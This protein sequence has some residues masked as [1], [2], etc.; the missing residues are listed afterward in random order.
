M[1][2]YFPEAHVAVEVIPEPEGLPQAQ[3]PPDTVRLYVSEEQVS[4][5]MI[6]EALGDLVHQREKKLNRER[7]AKVCSAP[8]DPAFAGVATPDWRGHKA[9][10]LDG[11]AA[12]ATECDRRGEDRP[13]AEDEARSPEELIEDLL[14][15]QDELAASLAEL[16][17]ELLISPDLDCFEGDDEDEDET[18]TYDDLGAYDSWFQD[19][20]DELCCA[21]TRSMRRPGR[22]IN[23]GG[24]RNLYLSV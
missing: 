23:I 8:L 19:W 7:R 14:D 18:D 16:T 17:G 21:R 13:P 11:S 1:S 9:S 12:G 15:A 6:V 3:C 10:P 5:P 2:I 4:D 24:C 22:E 20:L